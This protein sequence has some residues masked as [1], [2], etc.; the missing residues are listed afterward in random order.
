MRNTKNFYSFIFTSSRTYHTIEKEQVLTPNTFYQNTKNDFKWFFRVIRLSWEHGATWFWVSDQWTITKVTARK[1]AKELIRLH[2]RGTATAQRE[3]E[4]IH[5]MRVKFY[6][7]GTMVGY[8]TFP[9]SVIVN[10]L[11]EV[12]VT[13]V[14]SSG[15]TISCATVN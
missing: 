3:K 8:E 15:S 14:G 7:R 11:D 6:D 13:V 4:S 9:W 10:L 5:E 2:E 1:I 12:M